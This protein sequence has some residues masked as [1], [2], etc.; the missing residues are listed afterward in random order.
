MSVRESSRER[1]FKRVQESSREREFK[2]ERER[3]RERESFRTPELQREF[4]RGQHAASRT[5][6]TEHTGFG[7]SGRRRGRR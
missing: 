5:V 2:R 4:E 3:A 1:E 7:R 6:V